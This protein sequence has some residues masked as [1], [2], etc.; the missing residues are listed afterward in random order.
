M[1]K[2]F[3][4]LLVLLCV[5]TAFGRFHSSF[6]HSSSHSSYHHSSYHPH[7]YHSSTKSSPRT[8]THLSNTRSIRPVYHTNGYFYYLLLNQSTHRHDTIKASTEQEVKD[9]VWE[10][11]N[12]EEGSSI[13]DGIIF[14]VCAICALGVMFML[15]GLYE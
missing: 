12:K 15:V 1:K 4:T 5:T 9:K 2:V 10:T 8:Y 11:S 6:H 3:L 13:A 7:S 14:I